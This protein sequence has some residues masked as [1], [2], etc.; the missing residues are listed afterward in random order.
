MVDLAGPVEF[1]AEAML[2]FLLILVVFPAMAVAGVI[3]LI[4]GVMRWRKNQIPVEP[5]TVVARKSPTL[6]IVLGL[7]LIIPFGSMRVKNYLDYREAVETRQTYLNAIDFEIYQPSVLPVGYEL[8]VSVNSF[9][10]PPYIEHFMGGGVV[11]TQFEHTENV[12]SFF[13]DDRP[14]DPS[15]AL[16]FLVLGTTPGPRRGYIPQLCERVVT[17]SGREVSGPGV[18]DPTTLNRE[19]FTRLGDTTI[20][21]E[22]SPSYQGDL[23]ELPALVDSLRPI[24]PDELVDH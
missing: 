7:V 6:F 16:S 22:F 3:F 18:P 17:P 8:D 2:F 12:D 13:R 5:G 4:L 21:F 14:C 24:D 1:G 11:M 19:F 9:R 15:A 10:D 23:S 20:V